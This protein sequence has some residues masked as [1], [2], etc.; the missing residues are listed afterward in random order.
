[1]VQVMIAI[2]ALAA[3]TERSD[4]RHYPRVHGMSF[5]PTLPLYLFRDCQR[6]QV[7]M[8]GDVIR[9]YVDMH[10]LR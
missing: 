8:P 3:R 7:S 10:M 1:M 5:S 2:M 6:C 4:R 9:R